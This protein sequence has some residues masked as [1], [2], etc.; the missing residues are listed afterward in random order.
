[1]VL[2]AGSWAGNMMMKYY[3]RDFPSDVFL[4]LE[5]CGAKITVGEF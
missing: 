2:Q 5:A 3:H 4:I 1:M